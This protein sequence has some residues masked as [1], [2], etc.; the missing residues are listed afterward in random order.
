MR[1]CLSYKREDD[2][3]SN[4]AQ[5]LLDRLY[6]PGVEAVLRADNHN[7][8]FI[9]Y[10]DRGTRQSVAFRLELADG[11]VQVVKARKAKAL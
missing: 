11:T 1:L 10:V 6:S 5:K 9:D 4:K 3:M 2:A 7:G 8:R